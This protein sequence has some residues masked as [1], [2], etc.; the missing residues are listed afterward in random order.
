MAAVL[1]AATVGVMGG[2]WRP[3][4]GGRMVAV[5]G[6]WRPCC[7]EE[8]GGCVGA[9][10]LGVVGGCSGHIRGGHLGGGHLGGRRMAAMLSV[11]LWSPCWEWPACGW[12]AEIWQPSWAWDYSSH[13]GGGLLAEENG[14]ERRWPCWGRSSC[15]R[16]DGSHV[17]G[18]RREYGSMLGAAI[19]GVG[20]EEMAAMLR[21][22]TLDVRRWLTSWGQ[23]C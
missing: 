22:A 21:V 6:L 2:R 19:L 7:G 11:G 15:R 12:E 16:K 3:C 23:T 1:R 10:I 20:V 5:L 13:V 9:A 4:W 14:G 18:G 8:H 17:G